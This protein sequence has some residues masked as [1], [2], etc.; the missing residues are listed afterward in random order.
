MK[1]KPWNH[2]DKYRVKEGSYRSPDGEDYGAFFIP[3]P[4]AQELKVIASTGKLD[5]DYPFD[6][7]SVSCKSRCPNWPEMEF[8]K[9]LFFSDDEY[10]YQLHV[11]PSKHINFHDYCLHIWRPVNQEIP[12]PP[13]IMVGPT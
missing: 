12:I 4:C 11:P 1:P 13:A 9:R 10:A 7:V 5:P 2:L 6:H 3:G 8:I